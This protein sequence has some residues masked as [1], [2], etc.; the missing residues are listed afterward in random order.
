MDIAF[1]TEALRLLCN[2]RNAA[3]KKIGAVAAEQLINRLKDLRA[4]D[5]VHD[6][7]VGLR[8][9]IYGT[10]GEIRVVDLTNECIL[11]FVAHHLKTPLLANKRVDWDKVS[12]VKIT[13]IGKEAED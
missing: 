9:A 7:V 12:R 2:N 5:S 10:N 8:A 11:M 6:L 4:A 1:E 13:G 3:A